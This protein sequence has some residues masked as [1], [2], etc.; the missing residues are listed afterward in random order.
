MEQI[1]IITDEQDGIAMECLIVNY[2]PAEQAWVNYR[3]ILPVTAIGGELHA[4]VFEMSL[5]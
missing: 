2:L 3:R 1:V 4:C 5:N